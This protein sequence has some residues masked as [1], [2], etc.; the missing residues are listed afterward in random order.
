[1]YMSYHDI[2]AMLSIFLV[3]PKSCFQQLLL[4]FANKS[5]VVCN[6]MPLISQWEVSDAVDAHPQISSFQPFP[7]MGR[8]VVIEMV[9][10]NVVWGSS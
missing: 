2:I 6:F 8:K 1:M 5:I 9:E 7:V 10:G 4:N 3:L